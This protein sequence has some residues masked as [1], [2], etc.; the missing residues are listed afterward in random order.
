MTLLQDFLRVHATTWCR[1]VPHLLIGLGT[2]LAV[3]LLELAARALAPAVHALPIVHI[4]ELEK[5][6]TVL[7][8][9]EPLH[10]L[11]VACGKQDLQCQNQLLSLQTDLGMLSASPKMKR[12]SHWD[13]MI[14]I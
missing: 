3:V 6:R 1:L 14:I 11:V 4:S 8:D 12:W 2:S 9:V 7:D 5:S 13:I 10:V